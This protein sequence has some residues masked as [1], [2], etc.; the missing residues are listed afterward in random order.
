MCEMRLN[1]IEIIVLIIHDL[2]RLAHLSYR[3]KFILM[4]EMI[5]PQLKISIR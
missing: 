2:Y 4:L 1:S 5:E 3:L